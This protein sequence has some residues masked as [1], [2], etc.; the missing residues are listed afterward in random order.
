M[1]RIENRALILLRS[2]LLLREHVYR[3]AAQK[4]PWYIRPSQGRYIAVTL[5]ATIYSRITLANATQ[6]L[7]F[8]IFFR[9][10]QEVRWQCGKARFI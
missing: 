9:I 4:R 3:A 6:K 1:D 10:G 5:H 8:Q 2:C 7:D